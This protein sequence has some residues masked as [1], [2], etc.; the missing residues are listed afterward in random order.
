M[1]TGRVSSLLG[2][3]GDPPAGLMQQGVIV[4]SC[5]GEDEKNQPAFCGS[6]LVPPFHPLCSPCRCRPSLVSF[7]RDSA[8][9]ALFQSSSLQTLLLPASPPAALIRNPVIRPPRK[10]L[11]SSRGPAVKSNRISEDAVEARLS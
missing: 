9:Q 3:P 8:C 7:S 6:L 2:L 10:S 1:E 5:N 4:S 11:P